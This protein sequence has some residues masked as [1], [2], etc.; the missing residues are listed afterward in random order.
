[1]VFVKADSLKTIKYP[2]NGTKK[3]VS[4]NGPSLYYHFQRRY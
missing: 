4:A 2:N 3:D 1:V